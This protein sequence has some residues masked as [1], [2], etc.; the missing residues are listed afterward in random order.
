M[1]RTQELL[2]RAS[3]FADRAASAR[4]R[5]ARN[6]FLSLEQSYRNLAAHQERFEAARQ[7][8]APA[9]EPNEAAAGA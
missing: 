6:T 8:M 9:S 5:T 3:H 2:A 4:G 7:A 1:T